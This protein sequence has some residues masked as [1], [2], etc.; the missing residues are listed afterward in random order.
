M[1]A[2]PAPGSRG[3]L[4]FAPVAQAF[5]R[6]LP[7]QHLLGWSHGKPVTW[8]ELR[9]RV[10]AMS[11]RLDERGATGGVLACSRPFLFLAAM[12]ALW[13]RGRE[14][15]VPASLQPDAVASL[16]APGIPVLRDADFESLPA[17]HDGSLELPDASSCRLALYTSGSSGAPKRVDKTLA[18][19]DRE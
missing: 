12:L 10:A 5:S 17:V 1:A 2:A 6:D 9:A 4:M 13:Q 18:Q 11:R 19:L 7:A 3:A 16:A 8:G 14:A 15:L